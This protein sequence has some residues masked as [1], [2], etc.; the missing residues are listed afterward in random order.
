MVDNRQKRLK[1]T[2]SRPRRSFEVGGS[3]SAAAG[4][5]VARRDPYI[6]PPLQATRL[7]KFSR[8]KV[9][10]HA[11]LFM[12][13]GGLSSSGAHLDVCENEQWESFN[14]VDMYKSFL[15][16]PL[17][18]V[19]GGQTK[20]GSLTVESRL[21][22]YFIAYILVQR[23][24]NHAQLTTHDFKLM[25]AI[26]EGIQVNWPAEILKVMFGI[27]SS[28]SRLLAY[29]IFISR[30][31]YY[32]EIET[33]NVDFQLTNTLD[34]LVGEYL[35]HKMG[36]YWLSGEWMY[37]VE[38][39]TTIDIDLSDEETPAGQPEQPALQVEAS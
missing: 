21:L 30:I 33:P 4:R 15:R 25:F 11:D 27:A 20:V 8:E 26:R 16:G 1:T 5:T 38:Y 28:S 3:S 39:R 29:G 13:I 31:I 6:S 35:I 10:L 23:N 34:H 22:H 9:G 12:A 32:M 14:V 36:I 19:P 18:F 2:D 24:T 17:Y 7:A 37:Q